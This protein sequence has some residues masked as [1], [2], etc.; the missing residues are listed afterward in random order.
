M[1]RKFRQP[2][3]FIPVIAQLKRRAT[4]IRT[5]VLHPVLAATLL[6]VMAKAAYA[7]GR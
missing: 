7:S 5:H 6:L 2:I 3:E 1:L 4:K